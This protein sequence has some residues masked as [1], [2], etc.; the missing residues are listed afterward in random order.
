MEAPRV[1][2]REETLWSGT[3]SPIL[4]IGKILGILFVMIA[5]PLIAQ[6]FASTSPDL[7]RADNIR[8]IGWLLTALVTAILVIGLIVSWIKLRATMYTVTNQRV[9]VETGVFS[10]TVNEIDLRYVDDSQ[11]YQSLTDRMLGIGNVT[12]ISSDKNT[13]TYVLRS[14]RDPRSVRELIRANAYQISQ[15]QIFTRAT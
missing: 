1:A 13:P 6:F 12:L 9:M 10:K 4:L 7:E 8:R 14:I 11:F 5:I 15:R 2:A 3:P